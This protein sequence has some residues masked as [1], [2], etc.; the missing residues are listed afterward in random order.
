[1]DEVTIDIVVPF[2]YRVS[3]NE[4][5]L[6]EV[7]RQV[8]ATL[9]KIPKKSSEIWQLSLSRCQETQKEAK[10]RYIATRWQHSKWCAWLEGRTKGDH[11]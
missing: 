4:L 2:Q 10:L 9:E 5:V 8:D 3:K 11:R 6:S 7:I 1:M